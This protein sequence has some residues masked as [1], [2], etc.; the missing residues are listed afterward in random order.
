MWERGTKTFQ[1]EEH[2]EQGCGIG[3]MQNM[4]HPI[5]TEACEL[6]RGQSWRALNK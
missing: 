5:V 1:V 4:S 3:R 6:G 2:S